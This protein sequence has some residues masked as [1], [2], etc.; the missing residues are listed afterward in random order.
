MPMMILL[1]S[2]IFAYRLGLS[3]FIFAMSLMSLWA[4]PVLM[5]AKARS[6]SAEPGG[7]M[8]IFAEALPWRSNANKA[9]QHL[10]AVKCWHG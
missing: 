7:V 10:I 1:W 3:F 2:S 6:D 9:M 8:S 4:V 5:D